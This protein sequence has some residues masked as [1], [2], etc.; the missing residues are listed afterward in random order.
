M[1]KAQL[2]E[3]VK[4]KETLMMTFRLETSSE[5]IKVKKENI[6]QCP[7]PLLTRSEVE[8]EHNR[9]TKIVMEKFDKFNCG[10]VL[11]PCSECGESLSQEL[12][13]LHYKEHIDSLGRRTVVSKKPDVIVSNNPTAKKPRGRPRKSTEDSSKVSKVVSASP[14]RD[15]SNSSEKEFKCANPTFKIKAGEKKVRKKREKKVKMSPKLN[16]MLLDEE[17]RMRRKARAKPELGKFLAPSQ[18]V[19]TADIVPEIKLSFDLGTVGAGVK[20]INLKELSVKKRGRKRKVESDQPGEPRGKKR[21]TASV[22]V[23]PKFSQQ[24]HGPPKKRLGKNHHL[25]TTHDDRVE[26]KVSPTF[27]QFAKHKDEPVAN[28]ILDHRPSSVN[29]KENLQIQLGSMNTKVPFPVFLKTICR[30][31][32]KTEGEFIIIC[33]RFLEKRNIS[34]SGI[35]SGSNEEIERIKENHKALE[36][37]VLYNVVGSVENEQSKK[38]E[39]SANTDTLP[40]KGE[41]FLNE[42]S[43]CD[44]LVMDLSDE[45]T[46]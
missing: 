16:Q 33:L 15:R 37:V 21:D 27:S 26:G 19:T 10:A 43:D 1:N 22:K 17:E 8:M 20:E 2:D 3:V 14:R 40:I 12:L 29:V 23:S 7:L 4:L 5:Q 39:K 31:A 13:I 42:S 24:D 38:T 35:V 9:L 18:A 44:N 28:I 6:D 36:E 46:G 30:E 25:N 11:V 45:E 34:I 32:N 41:D